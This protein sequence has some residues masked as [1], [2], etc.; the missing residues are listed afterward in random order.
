[1]LLRK[2]SLRGITAAAIGSLLTLGFAATTF[3][4][5][6]PTPKAEIFGGYS[7]YD[8]GHGKA[9][10]GSKIPDMKK[11]FGAAGT[12]NF[13]RLVGLTVD[14]GGHFNKQVNAYSIMA[15]PQL[16]F[17]TNQLSP[18][19][20]ALIGWQRISPDVFGLQE[21]NHAA[22]ALGGGLDLEA[23]RWLSIRIFQADWIN[24]AY[25]DPVL[26][27]N[28]VRLDGARI[29]GGLVLKLGTPS[30]EKQEVNATCGVR[31]V[32]SMAG[33]PVSVTMFTGGFNPKRTLSYAWSTNAGKI[34]GTAETATLDTKGVAPGTY[35]ITG[36]V[37][38]NGKG[39]NQQSA[40]CNVEFTIKE[41][42]KVPPTISCA[43]GAQTVRAGDPVTI[44]STA[45]SADKRP[46]TYQYTASAGRVSGNGATA[47]L[48]TAG[49]PAGPVNITCTA[50][51]DRGL[52]ANGKTSVNVEVPPP[53]APEATKING[54]N[55]PNTKKPARVDNAA[56]AVLD[57]V[58]LRLQREA[59]AKAV[60][61]GYGVDTK[62]EKNLAAQRAVNTKAYLVEEKG[63]DPSRIS[64][65]QSNVDQTTADIWIVPT[66]AVFDTK[67]TTAVDENKI[68]P[69]KKP[70]P[71]PVKA[72]KPA[73]KK[74]Q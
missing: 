56:K 55:F 53:A 68:K 66:G 22:T 19:V 40:T 48:D 63:I 18:F 35:N 33:E 62:T 46:L 47:T 72:K 23:G 38:D 74:G 13:N 42:P 20:H 1:M 14:F 11:G 54:I 67:G 6:V 45:A 26:L 32:A 52:T 10:N 73:A 30:E 28:R 24:T 71:A 39:K 8:A 9:F 12:Y 49:A 60:V 58:A 36:K 7:W 16:K 70:A 2:I 3:A 59:D 31:P 34:S 69:A 44:T 64:V 51:D 25:K 50:T 37:T 17:R 15:G 65:R 5:D 43:P 21:Y 61:V 4:Q 27:P 29:Q 41:P 57:D